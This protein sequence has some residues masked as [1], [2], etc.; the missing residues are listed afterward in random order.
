VSLTLAE[1][2]QWVPEIADLARSTRES[3]T[4]HTTSADF[5]RSLANA[6]T[7]EGDGGDAAKAAMA[8]SADDHAEVAESLVKA[9]TGMEHAHQQAE[10]VAKTI[11]DILNDAAAQPSV[12]INEA[13]N[14][15]IP[16]DTTYL[17]D[18]A[19]A[20][21]AAKVADLQ[22]RIARVL[23]DGEVVDT[24]LAGAIATATGTAEPVANAASPLENL[25]LPN[26]GDDHPVRKPDEQTPA[27][28]DLDSAL[29]QLAGQASGQP[30]APHQTALP[31]MRPLDP[32]K[33]EQ[34]KSLA[35]QTMQRD[36]VPADQIEARLDAMVNAAQQPL[37][38]YTPPR[39]ESMPPPGFGDGFADR[40][41]ATEEGIKN[42]LGQGGPGAPGVLESWKD[43]V[44]STNDQLANPVGTAVG[45]VE[46]ALNSP[47]AAY[48]LGEKS[49]DAAV[50]AP[51]LIFGGEGALAARA[52]VLDDLA[53]PGAIPQ[54][55]IDSPAASGTFESSV[56]H[57]PMA[58]DQ[59]SSIGDAASNYDTGVPP[60]AS[61]PA[62][63]PPDSPLFDGYDPTPPGPQFTG[64]D[65]GLIYPDD[66]LASKPYAVPGTVVDK[67]DIP[68]GTVI[69][70]FG[71]PYGS[72]LSPDGTPFSERALAPESAS[73]IYN[74][75]VVDDPSLLP[76]GF[77]IEQSE[78]APWFHQPGGGIQ[79][80]IIGPDGNNAAVNDLL[81]SGYLRDL[82]G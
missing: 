24:E 75:Y 59:P 39:P 18:E 60:L 29:G 67:A 28:T 45:E 10:V 48:Y 50:T 9:A 47:S 51:S 43:L 40:W 1:L 11:T 21:L 34:F 56:P 5:Y 61:P 3:S 25:L 46:H 58:G 30:P 65:G 74:H 81:D 7:W 57:S 32:T 6:T 35:R 71:S 13:T 16:P 26:G 37:P 41:F 38:R 23:A 80:R 54:E 33:V 73:K 17:T 53:A 79:Y 14:Q 49:A 2:K 72:W 19:A 66:S 20:K 77:R 52:G 31:A 78:V 63:L 55:L 62:P 4:S 15:V 36:G 82:H 22:A 68:Q 76:P 42:L 69:D 27:P 44:K 70:R 8:A 64:P 12:Q